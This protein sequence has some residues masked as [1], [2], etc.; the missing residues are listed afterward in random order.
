M[1]NIREHA[2]G[3]TAAGGRFSTLFS[4]PHQSCD[5][6][7]KV[8]VMFVE[9]QEVLG[10]S[11]QVKQDMG[12]QREKHKGIEHNLCATYVSFLGPYDSRLRS[13]SPWFRFNRTCFFL[14]QWIEHALRFQLHRCFS[15]KILYIFQI[16][17]L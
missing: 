12:G 11:M 8:V 6:F 14:T 1:S 16:K 10:S 9:R 4:G 3:K 2:A 5:V 15:S 13:R 17:P 7:L